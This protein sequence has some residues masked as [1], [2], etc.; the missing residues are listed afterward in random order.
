M[1]L[2]KMWREFAFQKRGGYVNTAERFRSYFETNNNS[3]INYRN[4]VT[5]NVLLDEMLSY[6]F[7]RKHSG[8][9]TL[10]LTDRQA[11]RL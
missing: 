10:S 3:N 2:L 6:D 1:A 11:S 4:I 7:T 5:K 8:W 9:I